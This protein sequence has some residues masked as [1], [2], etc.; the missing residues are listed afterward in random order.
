MSLFRCLGVIGL[1]ALLVACDQSEK[2]QPTVKPTAPVERPQE[3]PTPPVEPVAPIET[4]APEQ[5]EPAAPP[6]VEQPTIEV[7]AKPESAPKNVTQAK[8]KPTVKPLPEHEPL[9]LSLNPNVFDPLKPYDQ[10]DVQPD[11]LL[12]PLFE[13]KPEPESPFQLNG[14]LITNDSMQGDYWDTVE[15]AQLNFEFK[16]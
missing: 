6:A 4:S 5:P 11:K 14:K 16:Q 15:G 2:A 13:E 10:E 3:Q 7:K 12:P 8:P 9:N 1:A